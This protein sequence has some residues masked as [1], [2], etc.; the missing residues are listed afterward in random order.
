MTPRAVS[1]RGAS[2]LE[3]LVALSILGTA[4]L[5]AMRVVGSAEDA[6]LRAH[7]SES[8]IARA[9]AFLDAVSI[10]TQADLDRHLGVRVQ[11][12]WRMAVAQ[13]DG[14]YYVALFDS[15]GSRLVLETQFH[16]RS[17]RQASHAP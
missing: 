1:R 13:R 5:A 8:E 9:S 17:A 3:A 12:A 4:I 16:F 2:L 14:L 6:L 15:T 7:E 11:G 10:W